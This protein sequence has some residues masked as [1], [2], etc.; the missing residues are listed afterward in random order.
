MLSL[1]ASEKKENCQLPVLW[2]EHSEQQLHSEGIV[3]AKTLDNEGGSF[4]C[5]H[6]V[7]HL[8]ISMTAVMTQN[9]N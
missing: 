1:L 8:S 4:Q 5:A 2:L 6:G 3:C 9:I 7:Q